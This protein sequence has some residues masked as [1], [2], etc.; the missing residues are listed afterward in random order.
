MTAKTTPR[1]GVAFSGGGMRALAYLGVLQVLEEAN[2]SI[3]LVA[4]TSIGGFVAGLYAAGV[5]VRDLVE[6]SKKIGFMD[7]ASPDRRW[8]GLLG[9]NK[10]AKLLAELLGSPDISFEE[11]NIPVAVV[12][13]DLE[14]GELVILKEGPLIPALMATSAYPFIFAPVRHQGRW[15]VDGG[16][17][18]N[19]PVDVVRRMGADR[20]LGVSV[21]SSVRLT[22]EGKMKAALSPPARSFLPSLTR[23]WK[24]PF[25]VAEA[26][27]CTMIGAINRTR[28]MLCP[29]DLLLEVRLPS[30]GLFT[31]D[32]NAEVIVAGRRAAMN[33]LAEL[34]ALKTKPLS[35]R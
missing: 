19:F 3:D 6:F 13:T 35:A 30:V 26:S 18:N 11:L 14:K 1:I 22:L 21:P 34:V 2:V 24:L 8:Q 16:V 28:L 27:V 17:L 31:T 20:V 32:R 23:D 4:G 7:F 15:L 12:A 9:H 25:L 29:P 5:P 10:M 33:H